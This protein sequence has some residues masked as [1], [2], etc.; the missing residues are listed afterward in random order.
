VLGTPPPASAPPGG[1]NNNNASNAGN[2]GN[3]VELEWNPG[4]VCADL[5]KAY[6]ILNDRQLKL[7]AKWAVEQWM[8]LPADVV[9]AHS[10]SD[11]NNEDNVN[12]AAVVEQST[13]SDDLLFDKNDSKNPAICYAKVLMELGEYQHAAATLSQPSLGKYSKIDAFH[14]PG[15]E[16]STTQLLMP[17][18]LCDLTSFG[19][20]L[21]AY[22]LYMAGERRKEEEYLE[23]KRYRCYLYVLLSIIELNITLRLLYISRN[24]R[25]LNSLL[26]ISCSFLLISSEA[27][28]Y[29]PSTNPYLHQLSNELYD[30]YTKDLL[31]P[32]GL[33]VYGMVLLKQQKQ[34]SH[35]SS[36][37]RTAKAHSPQKKK[38][39]LS[40]QHVL[41][42]SILEFPYNWSAWL[43]L[44]EC[45]LTNSDVEREIEQQLQPY[46]AG[47]VRGCICISRL[48]LS[49]NN[50]FVVFPACE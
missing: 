34:Q 3:V 35:S 42:K 6:Q 4:Q 14:H 49:K 16:Q 18:P 39:S 2:N 30:C 23:L 50:V 12:T 24:N 15:G 45:A 32:F 44:A 26:A 28:K 7:S 36:S 27:Q 41:M 37:P 47:Y 10:T 5:Q 31:D 38:Q 46:L 33:H 20:Y 8:G 11:N 48:P 29:A 9:V 40:P 21:R 19:L 1:N 13:I 25:P 22:A 43:D 17:P